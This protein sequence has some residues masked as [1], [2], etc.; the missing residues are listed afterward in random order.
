MGG[1]R[2]RR[3]LIRT[4]LRLFTVQ[5]SWNYE[6]MLG[7]GIG[8]AAEPLLRE[9]PGGPEGERYRNAVSRAGGYFNAH[10]YLTGLAAGA[11]ARAEHEEVGGE[12]ISRFR[13]ALLGP[14]GSVGDQLIWAGTLP[15]SVGLGLI[16]TA[17]ASPA[18]GVVAFLVVY[19]VAHLMLRVWGLHAGWQLGTGLAR[20][21]SAPAVTV[22]LRL[23][24]P[25]ASVFVG[26]ALPVTGAWLA[27]DL[28]AG[29]RLAAAAMYV[30]A[31]GVSRWLAPTLRGLRLGLLA[32]AA[33]LLGEHL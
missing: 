7:L 8:Y 1:G 2:V 22:G 29:A 21:L 3:A 15:A 10:P 20:A 18:V 17:V 32:A 12:Q 4:G 23:V 16:L 24:G 31:F 5:G 6:R 9:L 28:P 30:V 27:Q 25:M 13:S 14:L 26:A 19:N 33:V 11:I